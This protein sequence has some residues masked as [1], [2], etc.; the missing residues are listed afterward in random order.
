MGH[1]KVTDVLHVDGHG[2][3]LARRSARP[4]PQKHARKDG[5]RM[6]IRPVTRVNGHVPHLKAQVSQLAAGQVAVGQHQV[7]QPV[8]QPTACPRQQG[9]LQGLR[10]GHRLRK[11]G[12]AIYH[13]SLRFRVAE[14]FPSFGLFRHVQVPRSV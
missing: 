8:D 9:N 7:I 13:Q 3:R 1:Q 6:V 12:Q 11:S 2:D 14:P 5:A 4:G 10:L